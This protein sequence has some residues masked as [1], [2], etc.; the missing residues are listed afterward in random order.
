MRCHVLAV[1]MRRYGIKSSS[2]RNNRSTTRWFEFVSIAYVETRSHRGD[3]LFSADEH[4]KYER[5]VDNPRIPG[6]PEVVGAQRCSF[7]FGAQ[8]GREYVCMSV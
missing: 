7:Y 1:R 8:D 5:M 4:L 3:F 6:N 2:D